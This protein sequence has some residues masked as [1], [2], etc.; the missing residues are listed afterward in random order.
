M[1]RLGL[2]AVFLLALALSPTARAQSGFV[3]LPSWI[4]AR[5]SD[6]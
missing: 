2:L 4:V 6:R 5:E 1:R 3:G